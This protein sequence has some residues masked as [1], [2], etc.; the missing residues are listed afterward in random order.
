MSQRDWSFFIFLS[1]HWA[2]Y[3]SRN[4]ELSYPIQWQDTYWFYYRQGVDKSPVS[5]DNTFS[6]S[7]I[8]VFISIQTPCYHSHVIVMWKISKAFSTWCWK[9]L[10]QVCELQNW[11]HQSTILKLLFPN[12]TLI[13]YIS[14]AKVLHSKVPQVYQPSISG[15]SF[16]MNIVL[17][18][19]YLTLWFY[20]VTNLEIAK[21]LRRIEHQY[22]SSPTSPD[23]KRLKGMRYISVIDIDMYWKRF[24]V[25]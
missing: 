11:M 16:Y 24:N 4:W 25:I 17:H 7:F 18:C 22:L 14:I 20:F 6:T 8:K 19:C 3:P 12:F 23:Q 2:Q 15:I 13:F 21:E 5:H 1:C 10:Q 9:S